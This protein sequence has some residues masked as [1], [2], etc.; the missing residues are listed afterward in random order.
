MKLVSNLTRGPITCGRQ[1]CLMEVAIY[2][3]FLQKQLD[4]KNSAVISFDA[5]EGVSLRRYLVKTSLTDTCTALANL[6]HSA[7]EALGPPPKLPTHL[8]CCG[9]KTILFLPFSH[10]SF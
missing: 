10:L 4:L 1:L 7:I 2:V 8:I 6:C 5:L 3:I 9:P